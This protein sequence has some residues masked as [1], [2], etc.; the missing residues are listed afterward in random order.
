MPLR[1]PIRIA[2]VLACAGATG[3]GGVPP[4][5]PPSGPTVQ[6]VFAE[7]PRVLWVAAHPDDESMG[8]PALSQACVLNKSPC[9]FF[10]FNRGRG[11]ECNLDDGCQPDLGTVRHRELNRAAR[12]YRA[13]LEHY[14]F[15]NAPL[16]V[17]SFPTRI[18][19]EKKWMAM[20][21]PVGLVARAIR[22]F[23]PSVIISLGPHR[24]FTGHPEHQAAARFAIAGARVAADPDSKNELVK[25]ESPHRISHVFHVLNKYWFMG[26]AGDPYDPGA[27]MWEL[28]NTAH[29]EVDRE[30]NHRRCVDTIVAHTRVHHS[31]DTDMA[32]VRTASKFW[33]TGYIRRVDPFGAEADELIAEIVGAPAERP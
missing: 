6:D 13:T 32:A 22:R 14:D 28:D 18:E 2:A 16:P 5:E 26:I 10:V 31:Q 24:G 27:H 9:H 12:L 33:G 8:G 4:A 30:G 19:L 3:C 15:Y 7:R 29:C 21:D 1:L 11:G 23:R 17:E 20:G 25:G